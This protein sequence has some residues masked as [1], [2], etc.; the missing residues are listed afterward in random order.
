MWMTEPA[1]VYL[2]AIILTLSACLA[3]TYLVVRQKRSVTVAVK[4]FGLGFTVSTDTTTPKPGMAGPG[5]T[6]S[7]DNSSQEAF[8]SKEASIE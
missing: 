7:I 6:P 2:M 1:V 4:L 5:S 8:R 3:T